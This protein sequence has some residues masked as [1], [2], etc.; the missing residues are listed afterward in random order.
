MATTKIAYGTDVQMTVTALNSN[1]GNSATAAWES[2]IVDNRTTLALDYEVHCQFDLANTAAANDK[3]IRIY[4][5]PWF[6]DGTNWF[7][8]ADIGTVTALT[9]GQADCTLGST[10]NLRLIH[11]ISYTATDQIVSGHF[12]LAQI[13][14]EMPMGWSLVVHNFTGAAFAASGNL[15]QYVPVNYTVA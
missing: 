4:A 13:F 7:P 9:G 6:H 1:A 5:V 10:H 15:I 8:G 3:L 12:N 14:P 2:D 11:S